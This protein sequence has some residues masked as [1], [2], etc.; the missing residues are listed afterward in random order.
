[1]NLSAPPRL[2]FLYT[3]DLNPRFGSEPGKLRPVAVVQTDLLNRALHPSTLVCP[4]TTRLSAEPSPLRVKVLPKGARLKRP[5][6]ILVDQLRAIDNQRFRAL[7]GPLAPPALAEL[8]AKLLAILDFT[9]E[10][11]EAGLSP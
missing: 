4:L 11:E 6:E 10:A 7:I 9:A 8:R 3:A 2:G 1:M 5:S